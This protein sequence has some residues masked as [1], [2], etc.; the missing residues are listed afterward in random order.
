[1]TSNLREPSQQ[2]AVVMA[3]YAE[4][5]MVKSRKVLRL[6]F[7]LPLERQGEV[8][9]TLGA[10]MPDKETWCAIALLNPASTRDVS[11]AP[12]PVPLDRRP[13]GEMSRS[14][15]GK[16]RYAEASDQRKAV[17]RAALLAQDERFQEWAIDGFGCG[18]GESGAAEFI[19]VYCGVSSR[20]DIETN[21]Q[22]YRRFLKLEETYK[23]TTGQMAEPR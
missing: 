9:S 11:E 16:A 10:P 5:A 1:M 13:A 6:V 21:D 2:H 15:Q 14:E 8:L 12:R 20:G 17:T 23:F 19:R 4:W 7:E 18:S 3:T 22:A